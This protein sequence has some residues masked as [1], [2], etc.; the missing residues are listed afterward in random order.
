MT[1]IEQKQRHVLEQIAEA[2]RIL[3]AIEFALHH[4]IPATLLITSAAPGEGKSVFASILATTAA[5]SGKY[6]VAALDLNWYRP[7]LH[8]FF[9]L[10]HQHLSKTILDTDLDHLVCHCGQDSL[11]ILT[12]PADYV[13]QA[14]STDQIVPAIA[15]LIKQANDSYDL[16]II[17]SAAIFPTNRLMI[18][19]VVLSGI[20]AGVVMVVL[21]AATP[22]QQ[23]RKAQKIM[24]TAGA[25][26]LG[27]VN[28]QWK[29]T[30]KR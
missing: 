2:K 12:A 19:P 29:I 5:K 6:R 11:D 3:C 18:D 26:I 28:N 30:R 16:V 21:S 14:P 24:E 23:V 13:E 22:K 4:Q 15:R 17:D 27:V 25:N 7:A 20:T 8:R 10:D 1:H 9:D